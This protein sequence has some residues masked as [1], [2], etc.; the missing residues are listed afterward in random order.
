MPDDDA[1]T[2]G[3]TAASSPASGAGASGTDA[4]DKTGTSALSKMLAKLCK[5]GGS[6]S[7]IAC[8]LGST[9]GES[10]VASI[11]GARPA[12]DSL[13]VDAAVLGCALG[14]TGAGALLAR[15]LLASFATSLFALAAGAVE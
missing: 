8:E 2:V 1:E 7:L 3:A 15:P 10:N 9:A 5:P 14:L 11:L 13:P 12:E 6:D 4:S